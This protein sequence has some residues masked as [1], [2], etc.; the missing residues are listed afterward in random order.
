VH[1]AAFPITD[2]DLIP[3]SDDFAADVRQM[4]AGA[5]ELFRN[6]AVRS[7]LPGLL[8]EFFAD[9]DLHRALLERFETVVWRRFRERIA[10]A[11]ATGEVRPDVDADVLIDAISGAAFLALTLRTPSLVGDRWI[12]SLTDVLLKGIA[13]P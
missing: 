3:N 7:A 5:I 8:D 1:E 11:I 10:T 2:L 4:V 12:D 6:A 9:P 13:A